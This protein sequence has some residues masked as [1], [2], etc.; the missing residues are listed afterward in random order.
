KTSSSKP[1]AGTSNKTSPTVGSSSLNNDDTL[2]IGIVGGVV[3][4]IAVLIIVICIVRIRIT[5]N[6]YRGGPLAAPGGLSNGHAPS[7]VTAGSGCTCVKPP[8]GPPM[9]ISPYGPGYATLP[10]KL[11]PPTSVSPRPPYSTMGRHLITK[12]RPIISLILQRR[13]NIGS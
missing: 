13:K 9:Y 7:M 3:A 1:S 4:F 11:M 2:I 12:V 5:N 6:Q 8:M 10:P